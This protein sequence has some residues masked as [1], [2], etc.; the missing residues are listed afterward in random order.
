MTRRERNGAALIALALLIAFGVA[1]GAEDT[2]VTLLD[3]AWL[4]AAALIGRH[5]LHLTETD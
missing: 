5:G 1:G 3:L 2:P 4:A